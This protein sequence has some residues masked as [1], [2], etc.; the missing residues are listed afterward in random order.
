MRFAFSFMALAA[1]ST[2]GC[3][4]AAAMNQSNGAKMGEALAFAGA[5]AAA[6]V[7]Q[8]AAEARARNNAPVTHSSTGV[9]VTPQ[10]DNDGQYS[11]V[12]VTTTSGGP[13]APCSRIRT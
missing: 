5:A 4:G 2:V 11:C 1:C 9:G 10:C 12:T 13:P 8:S 7:V 6:Q 3:L